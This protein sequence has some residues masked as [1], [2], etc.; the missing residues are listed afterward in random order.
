MNKE[1]ILGIIRHILTFGGG[2][3]VGIDL[4]DGSTMDSTVGAIMT[5]V[6]TVWSAASPE[7]KSNQ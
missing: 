2:Y 6:G 4:I 1:K 7:K 5:I 3:L